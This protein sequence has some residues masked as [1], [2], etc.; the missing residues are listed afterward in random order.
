MPKFVGTYDGTTEYEA[1]SVVDNGAGT[2][3]VA[4][5]PV[6]VGTPLSN[7]DYW[8]VYGAS[9]G[10]ILDLQSR[11]QTAENEI[12]DINGSLSVLSKYNVR[13][14]GAKGD[15]V[16]DD[17]LAIANCIADC[18][19]NKDG[20]VYVPMGT[21]LITSPIDL[22][23]KDGISIIGEN[24]YSSLLYANGN[25]SI[26]R[27][28]SMTIGINI[29]HLGF[30]SNA[31]QNNMVMVDFQQAKRFKII[32]CDFKNWS[33]AL[34]LG[35]VEQCWVEDC[36]FEDPSTNIADCAI[37]I[38]II[39][40]GGASGANVMIDNCFIRGM[41]G[42]TPSCNYGVLVI[43]FDAVFMQ[44]TDIGGVIF[45]DVKFNPSTRANNHY[46]NQ[47][48][49]DATQKGS[50][51]EVTGAGTFQRTSFANCWFASAGKLTSP[52]VSDCHGLA[53]IGGDIAGLI[54]SASRFYNCTG[55]GVKCTTGGFGTIE[56]SL[57]EALDGIYVDA[58]INN[59]TL[60]I[61]GNYLTSAEEITTSATSNLIVYSNNTGMGGSKTFGI[62]P[63]ANV[64]N[65]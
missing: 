7:T 19:D 5:K 17:T 61:Q 36:T 14:Y 65:I 21:Y 34:L 56:N 18:Y 27:T 43:D 41:R 8:A 54:V 58:P 30:R 39:N 64:N 38:G 51:V 62:A 22:T 45:N 3:Y 37:Q 29:A 16:T 57:F 10:A 48:F 20:V 60:N 59:Y 52:D 50:C 9:S 32:D 25:H 33:T 46:F 49:F 44:N 31:E 12:I 42:A 24:P 40:A 28:T 1:L 13:L 47:C 15:G 6:P 55:Y 2:T 35:S 26:F 4:N 63:R 11:M 53:L 23:A